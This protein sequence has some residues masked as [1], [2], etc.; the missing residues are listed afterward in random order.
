MFAYELPLNPPC[1]EWQDYILPDLCKSRIKQICE[2]ILNR[3]ERTIYNQIYDAIYELIEA[4]I[5]QEK[6]LNYI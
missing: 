4:D 3:G 6:N 2:D 5:E 1:D